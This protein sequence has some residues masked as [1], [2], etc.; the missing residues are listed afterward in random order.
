MQI[1]PPP[2]RSPGCCSKDKK[3]ERRGQGPR[4]FD[5]L[6]PCLDG[7]FTLAEQHARDGLRSR[8]IALDFRLAGGEPPDTKRIKAG[9]D[10]S[11]LDELLRHLDAG[12]LAAKCPIEKGTCVR[13][14]PLGVLALKA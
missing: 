14:L 10:A 11:R 5:F 12:H 3:G 4:R 2:R 6:T 1:R 9:C 7:E 8:P 13:Y